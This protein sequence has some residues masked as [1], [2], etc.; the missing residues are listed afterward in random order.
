MDKSHHLS[1]VL[2]R[3]ILYHNIS[4]VF[5]SPVSVQSAGVLSEEHAGLTA[6]LH[7]RRNFLNEKRI[8]FSI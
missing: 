2:L 7:I 8:L 5:Y 6:T 3:Q 4:T 1:V